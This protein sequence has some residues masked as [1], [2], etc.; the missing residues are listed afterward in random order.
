MD[1]KTI[2]NVV[3][4]VS[5]I[6]FY[7]FAE[8][9][10]RSAT[11]RDFIAQ[12]IADAEKEF[13]DK[14]KAGKEKMSWVLDHLYAKIPLPLKPFFSRADLENLVQSI[15]DWI[16]QYAD[17]QVAKLNAKYEASKKKPSAK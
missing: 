14:E 7:L 5:V 6:I 13:A 3:C 1:W 10:K 4:V 2:F 11:L 15:F 8:Y 16:A 9:Y 12:L 17:I